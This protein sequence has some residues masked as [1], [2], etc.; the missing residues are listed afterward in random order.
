[1]L[2]CEASKTL[3]PG[4]GRV[5]LWPA[6]WLGGMAVLAAKAVY[7]VNAANNP[8]THK[9]GLIW[10]CSCFDMVSMGL[11][12]CID[13]CMFLTHFAGSRI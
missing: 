1:M 12:D 4:P 3:K 2:L 10:R 5:F 11:S 8:A 9:V 7:A 13:K 6:L